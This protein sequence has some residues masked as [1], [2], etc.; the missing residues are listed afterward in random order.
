[1]QRFEYTTLLH[2]MAREIAIMVT[3]FTWYFIHTL[4]FTKR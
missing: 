3:S 1:M 2:Q 4:I